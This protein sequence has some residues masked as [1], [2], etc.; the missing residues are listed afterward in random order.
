MPE[1]WRVR[2]YHHIY[3]WAASALVSLLMWYELQPVTV[4]VGWAV[5]GL[6]LFEYGLMRNVRQFRFQSYVALTAAFTRI[7]FA[8]LTAATPGEFWGPRIYTVLPITLIL[9]FV[10]SQLG[11]GEK[12]VQDDSRLRFDTLLAYLGS[13][14]VVALLFPICQRLAGH[15]LGGGCLR[16]VRSRALAESPDLPA[17]SFASDDGS[18]YPRHHAQPLRRKLLY[19]W[20]LDGEVLRSGFGNYYS[21]RLFAVRLPLARSWPVADT[22]QEM[23]G[24]N[25]STS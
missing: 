23:A 15:G 14:T 5:F 12:N 3:S 18:L 13:G 22:F 7:F 9:L 19:R 24:C 21:L 17:S 20:H 8:N 1:D 6:V 10:Y 2:E 25:C 4:A 16:S 11:A